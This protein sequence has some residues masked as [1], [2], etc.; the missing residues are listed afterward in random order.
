VS[1]CTAGS[2][3]VELACVAYVESVRVTVESVR[4]TVEL[5]CEAAHPRATWVGGGVLARCVAA[6]ACFTAL[7]FMLHSLQRNAVARR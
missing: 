6:G 3:T 5:A 7:E 4:A 2:A 1:V